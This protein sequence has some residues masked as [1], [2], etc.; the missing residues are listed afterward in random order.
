MKR[1]FFIIL[2]LAVKVSAGTGYTVTANA[3]EPFFQFIQ[4]Y[5]TP[6]SYSGYGGKTVIVNAGATALEF[7]EVPSH[8]H[9]GDTLE[10]DAV[11]SD[12]GAFAFNTTGDVT[13]NQSIE[14]AGYTLTGSSGGFLKLVSGDYLLL[15]TGDKLKLAEAAATNHILYL[16]ASGV[17][18]TEAGFE[19]DPDADT[20]TAGILT[21]GANAVYNATE[22]PGGELGGTF[23]SFTIDDGLAVTNWNLTTPTFTTSATV[24]EDLWLGI[25]SG[26]E[27]IIF[28]GTGNDISF[29]GAN[30]AIGTMTPDSLFE[31]DGPY[32]LAIETVTGDTTLDNTHSTLLVNATGNVTI[33]LPTAA[34]AF[35]NTDAIGRIYRTKKIDADADLVTI[36]GNGSETIDGATTAVLTV[37]Y[38]TI[39]IQSDG[40]NWW[41]L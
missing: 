34:S 38:E 1:A 7:G 14:A 6:E 11:D 15:V 22:V 8:V 19:Y 4:L 32:G 40:S 26:S 27:R 16:N 37:Q 3:E 23:A 39:T 36:D 17:F 18:T 21:E 30:V 31:V 35:N 20:L 33:T 13:F 41:I 25:G 24:S 2:F 9:D 5:D 10:L 12:G 29:M 28:D